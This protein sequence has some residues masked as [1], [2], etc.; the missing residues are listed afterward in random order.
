GV[1]S[2]LVKALF[3][4]YVAAACLVAA[5]PTGGIAGKVVD[6]SGA[7]VAG[8]KLTVTSQGT[9]LQRGSTTASDGGFL[10]PLLP[11]G[12]YTVAA[13]AAGFRNYEQRGVTVPVNV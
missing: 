11:P 4:M 1:K 6:P 12:V 8:A 3:G 10:F 5:D 7:L 9:G 2:I 13:E